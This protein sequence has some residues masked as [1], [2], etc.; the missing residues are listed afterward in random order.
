MSD[1]TYGAGESGASRVEAMLAAFSKQGAPEPPPAEA[2]APP[3]AAA[4]DA[5][6]GARSAAVRP[7]WSAGGAGASA[8]PWSQWLQRRSL[9]ALLGVVVGAVGNQLWHELRQQE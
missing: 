9:W 5:R 6:A 1:P 2:S 4:G 7:L 3:P 8:R